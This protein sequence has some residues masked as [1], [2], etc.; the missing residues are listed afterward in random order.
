[1]KVEFSDHFGAALRPRFAR[2]YTGAETAGDVAACIAADGSLVRARL[3]PGSPAELFISRVAAPSA[4]ST[5]SSWTSLGNVS[6]VSKVALMAS[7]TEV[8]LFYVHTDEVTIRYRVS[9]DNG[10]SWAAAVSLVTRAADVIHLAAAFNEDGSDWLLVWNEGTTIFGWRESIG[11][12]DNSGR[13]MTSISGLACFRRFDWNI[14]VT[15][16]D[17]GVRKVRTLI[18]GDGFAEAADDWGAFR[19]IVR[20][21]NGTN[22]VFNLPAACSSGLAFR[23]WW[24][25]AY[26]GNYSYS[27]ITWSTME[28]TADFNEELWREPVAFDLEP[29]TTGLAVAVGATALWLVHA[30]GVWLADMS[31][32]ALD[33]SEDV[34][35]AVASATATDGRLRLVLRNEDGRYNTPGSGALGNVRR[36]ARVSFSPGYVTASGPA[37]SSGLRYWV[38][39]LEYVTGPLAQLVVHGV[40]GWGLLERWRARRQFQ[41]ASGDKNLF[42][43][44]DFVFHRAGLDYTTES[45]SDTLTDLEPAFTIH[46][47]E[48]GS[49]T[50]ARLLRMCPDRL[51]MLGARAVG[52]ECADDQASSYGYGVDHTILKGRYREGPPAINRAQ[53]YGSAGFTE[54]FDFGSIDDDGELIDQQI[55]LNLTSEAKA[56]D[57]AEARLRVA[58][59]GSRR[60]EI[61]V[62]VNCGQEVWDVVEVTDDQA[63][64]DAARR[65]VLAWTIRYGRGERAAYD[66]TLVL[67]EP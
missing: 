21:V 42:N 28:N 36:G 51:K 37:W 11:S 5:F 1:V 55:D 43:L 62:P 44:L 6:A 52:I 65:R 61:V 27:R 22:V 13:T 46:P 14:A 29:T 3:L 23:V 4:G 63:G 15:G 9:S 26:S 60:D 59:M 18:Y 32:T 49:T 20:A 7:A 38:T 16:N 67:G 35:E 57:R 47:G 17:S 64:L 31:G 53:A 40:D 39:E 58:A 34:I 33:V 56:E 2:V 30:S 48:L 54:L 12:V 45:S 10:A 24:V 66:E 41:F 25:E 19:E 8:V 50:V